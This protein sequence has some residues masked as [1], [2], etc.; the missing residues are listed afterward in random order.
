MKK[1]LEIRKKLQSEFSKFRNE[2]Y[3]IKQCSS[4]IGVSEKTGGVYEKIRKEKNTKKITEIEELITRLKTRADN[5]QISTKE[6]IDLTN[7]M[8]SLFIKKEKLTD[9]F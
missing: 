1:T 7:K 3:N 5:P 6:L 4:L 8:E 9:Q 2:G